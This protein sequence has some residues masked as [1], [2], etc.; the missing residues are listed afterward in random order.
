MPKFL[1]NK[2]VRDKLPFSEMVPYNRV[3]T[4]N[5]EFI[6][7]L[8]TKLQEEALEVQEAQDTNELLDEIGDVYEVLDNLVRAERISWEKV[9]EM[10]LLKK[11]RR[12]GFEGRTFGIAVDIPEAH[13]SIEKFRQQPEKYREVEELEA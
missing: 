13:P 7:L 2:L 10:R 3:I 8:K 1:I 9:H 5:A 6:A 11:E 4:E 12:G